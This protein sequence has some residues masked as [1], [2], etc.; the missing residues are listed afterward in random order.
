MENKTRIRQMIMPSVLLFRIL[1]CFH[2]YF[3]QING[4]QT[5]LLQMILPLILLF[6]NLYFYVYFFI[7]SPRQPPL[8][9]HNQNRTGNHLYTHWSC[10]Y[11]CKNWKCLWKSQLHN[12]VCDS[13]VV[14]YA[15]YRWLTSSVH[16]FLL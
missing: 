12:T 7:Y 14:T 1:L 10:T 5:K 11:A 9:P 3:F 4:N 13:W 6:K 2:M 15:G 8:V 16:D